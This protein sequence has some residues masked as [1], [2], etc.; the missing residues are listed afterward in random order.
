MDLIKVKEALEYNKYTVQIFKTKEAAAE[1]LNKEIDG[2]KV[3]FGDSETLRAMKMYELLSAHNEVID[4]PHHDK[5][6]GMED[7]I[8][9][10]REAL[11]TDIFLTSVNALT[12]NGEILNMDGAGNRIAGS[13]FGHE[14]TY[15][16]LGINKIVP[17][18]MAGIDRI[19]NVAA[20]KNAHRKG[21]KTPCAI[22]GDRCYNCNSPER[23]CNTL[24]IHYKKMSYRPMEVIIIEEELGL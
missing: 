22:K 12:E 13:L 19:K 9:L 23:I 4:P 1:Y 3:G 17:D 15:F 11:L 8:R 20:P 14:K 10:G 16:V 6:K 5:T 18:I 7:F 21:K 2:K 24:A